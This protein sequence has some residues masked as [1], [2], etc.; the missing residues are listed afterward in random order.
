M[1][2]KMQCIWSFLLVPL[3]WALAAAE[4]PVDLQTLQKALKSYQSIDRLD[5]DFKQT[6]ILKDINLELKSEGHLTVKAPDQVEWKILKPEP[7]TVTLEQQKI[8][9]KSAS[10]TQSYQQAENPSAQDRE[11][12]ATLLT[13]LKLD[14]GAIAEKYTVTALGKNRYR[15]VAKDPHEPMIKALEMDMGSDNHVHQLVFDEVSGDQMRLAFGKPKVIY[16]LR[17]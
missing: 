10:G 5:V 7:M 13:W 6:K 2:P 11:S 9:I 15:F 4:T 1:G 17:K 14:A 16:R 12:Y 8:T 3:C